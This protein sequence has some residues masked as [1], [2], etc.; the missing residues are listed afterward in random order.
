MA[1]ECHPDGSIDLFREWWVQAETVVGNLW[2]W[3]R[4]GDE[5]GLQR[6]LDCWNYIRENLLDREHGEWYWGINP[7]GT[8]D[9]SRPKAG[10]W[11]CPYHNGRM[12]LQALAITD[13][14]LVL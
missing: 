12:C 2:A 8:P 3:K 14:A 11:K 10:F 9:L 5:A 13:C 1:Y 6:A 4:L 7:D